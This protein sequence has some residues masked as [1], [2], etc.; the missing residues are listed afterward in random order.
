MTAAR[1][2]LLPCGRYR[3][4]RS[5]K[6][7]LQPDPVVDIIEFEAAW[8]SGS[9]RPPQELRLA[10]LPI[11]EFPDPV[12]RQRAR[13]VRKI[14]DSIRVLAD[15]LVDTMSHAGGVGLAANQIGVLKRVIVIQLP[16]DEEAQVYV[17]P[18][19][20]QR[21]GERRVEEGCLSIPGFKATITRSIWVKFRGLDMESKLVRLK[22]E[23]LLAQAL[24][25]EIDHLNGILYVDHLASHEELVPILPEEPAAV[26]VAV[27]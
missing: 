21:E 20:V 1:G 18:E 22:A 3:A 10:V 23:G 16:D 6:H 27:G 17:N 4:V 13:K 9:R 24:E 26:E 14:G 2:L 12:L 25:H 7:P 15:D 19:I 8:T 5:G 11:I